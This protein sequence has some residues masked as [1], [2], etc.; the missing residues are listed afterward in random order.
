MSFF[1]FS[2]IFL[3]VTFSLI[4]LFLDCLGFFCSGCFFS[5]G[6]S[7][8]LFG[9]SI[10]IYFLSALSRVS[11]VWS[12]NSLGSFLFYLGLIYFFLFLCFFCVNFVLFYVS[13]EFIFVLMFIF[14]LGWGYSPERRQASFYI[15][16]YTLLVS[17]PFLVYV[18]LGGQGYFRSSFFSFVSWSGYWWCFLFLVFL[19]KLPVFGVHL[20]L[21]KAHVEAPVSGSMILAGVLLKLGGY[22]FFRFTWFVPFFVSTRGGYL[23]RIGVLG[24]LFSCFLC[25]RQ[26]DLKAF[27]AYSSVCHMGI[28]L[29]GIYSIV[30]SGY[31]GGVVMIV[32]HG[33]CSSCL[34]FILYVFY[35]RLHSRSLVVLKG[36]LF[37]FPVLGLWFFFFSVI[38]MGVPPS[39]SF[40]SEVFIFM[41]MGRFDFFSL[42]FGGLV[43]FLSGVY[44]IYIYVSSIHGLSFFWDLFFFVSLREYVLMYGHLYPCFLLGIFFSCIFWWSFSFKQYQIVVLKGFW[45]LCFICFLFCILF[46]I[47]FWF[48]GFFL[49]FIVEDF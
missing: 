5:D 20:W 44:R 37:L 2:W 13:F 38:N 26:V 1:D 3:L 4:F 27:V 32:G 8:V 11:E 43:L 48:M 49:F 12:N 30:T 15:V 45:S 24:S 18:L 35:E 39:I 41:R 19:V 29:A 25:L 34:F 33:L 40:F 31:V 22:G 28:G 36:C 10:W 7:F 6:L 17:F 47:L 42:F 9:L 14:L 16:F 46:F 21:P 23:Y